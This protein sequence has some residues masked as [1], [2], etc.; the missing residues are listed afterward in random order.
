M[1]G[2]VCGCKDADETEEEMELLVLACVEVVKEIIWSFP[3][4]IR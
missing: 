4:G 2:R 1:A 3:S